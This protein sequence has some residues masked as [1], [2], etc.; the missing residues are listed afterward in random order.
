MM[1]A[2][3]DTRRQVPESALAAASTGTG[4]TSYTKAKGQPIIA[5]ALT[6]RQRDVNEPAGW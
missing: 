2:Y 5:S 1:R 4:I 6:G 3:D